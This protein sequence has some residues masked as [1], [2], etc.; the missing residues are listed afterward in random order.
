MIL[1]RMF[2]P[3]HFALVLVQTANPPQ[4]LRIDDFSPGLPGNARALGSR[5]FRS[6][7]A[8]NSLAFSSRPC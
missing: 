7:G 4:G 5:R 8:T 2:M 3:C 6:G 1:R